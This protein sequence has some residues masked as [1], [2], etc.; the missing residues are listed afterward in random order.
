MVQ[1]GNNDLVS[2]NNLNLNNMDRAKHNDPKVRAGAVLLF[3]QRA[4]SLGCFS[5][6]SLQGRRNTIKTLL[7]LHFVTLKSNEIDW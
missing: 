3:P 1:P 6:H 4:Q 5:V 7:Y 2:R